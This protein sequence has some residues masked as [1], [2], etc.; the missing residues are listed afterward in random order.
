MIAQSRLSSS[1]PGQ[2]A[3]ETFSWSEVR[4]GILNIQLWL[5]ATAY[6]AILS[7]LYASSSLLI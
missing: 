2:G 1:T 3:T 7:G 5:S 6:F 4:R